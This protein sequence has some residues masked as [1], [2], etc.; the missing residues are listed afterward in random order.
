M[1]EE[2]ET[3]TWNPPSTI[4]E[5]YNQAA[6]HKW[7]SINAPTAGP[8]DEKELIMGNA[9]LQLYSL[10]TPNGNCLEAKFLFTMITDTLYLQIGQ[11]VGILLEELEVD[12][13]A[14]VV[15][16]SRGEQFSLGFC[17]LNPNSKIPAFF[18]KNGPDGM[19]LRIFE[20]NSILAYLA[21]KYYRH[22]Y[23]FVPQDKRLHTE[24]MNWMY[25]Q[26]A[27]QVLIF[28][29]HIK[30][31]QTSLYNRVRLPASFGIS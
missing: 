30:F 5:L 24:C 1:S 4:E 6:G 27:G 28:L 16:I 11:K 19:P 3:R 22:S 31:H 18:D 9:P 12:Y 23:E 7:S 14:N 15:N 20:S 25:W 2:T 21:K 8:R 29:L 10:A 13:D 26:A 17:E